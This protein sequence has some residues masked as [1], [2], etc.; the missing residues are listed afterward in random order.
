M[1]SLDRKADSVIHTATDTVTIRPS[2]VVTFSVAASLPFAILSV[3]PLAG[4]WFFD[5]RSDFP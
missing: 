5:F 3:T 4:P 1:M 2:C